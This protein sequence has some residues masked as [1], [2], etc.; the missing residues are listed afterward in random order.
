M[1]RDAGGRPVRPGRGRPEGD[2][3]AD[4]RPASRSTAPA[5]LRHAAVRGRMTGV[6]HRH[7]PGRA[8]ADPR[9]HPHGLPDAGDE[10][11]RQRRRQ[12]RY[13]YGGR[14]EV[15]LVVR[16]MIGQSWGQGAQH[17]QG[18]YSFLHAHARACKVVAPSTPH[19]A[20]GCLIAGDP[21]RQPGPVRRAPHAALPEGA[22]PGGAATRCPSGKARVAAPGEDVTV[23]GISACR[24]NACRPATSPRPSASA[25]R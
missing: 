7:G 8:A 16:A 10:P 17:S 20:K 3:A 19:D 23:V 14:V 18:L 21:R 24:S 11:A 9:P 15:P 6:A 22:G 12:D 5:R 4:A 1:A 13:M 2:P 25:P